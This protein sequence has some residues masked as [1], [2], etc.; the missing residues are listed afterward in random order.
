MIAMTRIAL[1]V[2]AALTICAA[3]VSAQRSVYIEDLTWPEV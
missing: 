3:R 2:V 1:V